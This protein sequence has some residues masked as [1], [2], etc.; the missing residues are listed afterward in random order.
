MAFQFHPGI[1][2]K[3]IRTRCYFITGNEVQESVSQTEIQWTI[4]KMNR[5]RTT[6]ILLIAKYITIIMS[7]AVIALGLS[8]LIG[9][10]WRIPFLIQYH[11]D[12]IAMV[13][14]TA[15]SFIL[16]G[17]GIYSL[18]YRQP[19]VARIISAVV[20]F[21]ATIILLQYFLGINSGID[22]LF[23]NHYNKTAN[24]F[25]GRM[26]PNTA[27]CFM[28][29]A[30]ALFFLGYRR[31]H[32]YT[33]VVGGII[34]VLTLSLSILF[35]S[36]YMSSLHQGYLWGSET[37]MAANT[38]IG[39]LLLGISIITLTAYQAK[40]ND[41]G[42]SKSL[43]FLIAFCIFITVILLA[44]EIKEGQE[45]YGRVS[46]LPET[47]IILGLL[48]ALLFGLVLRF[49]LTASSAAVAARKSWSL[50]RSTMD[51][52]EDGIMVTDTQGKLADFNKKFLE[53]WRLEGQEIRE[54]S[55][56]NITH[57]I[58]N[59]L[60]DKEKYLL[61]IDTIFKHPEEI[62]THELR[63][64][65]GCV[66]ELSSRP[67]WLDDK[68][69]GRVWCF[70]DTTLQKRLQDELARQATHD[71]LTELPNRALLLDLINYSIQQASRAHNK[72]VAL[73]LLDLDRFSKINDLF[74]RSKGDELLKL[75]GKRLADF[76]PDGNT[77]GRIGGDEFL[78]I[79]G[80]LHRIEDAAAMS[81]QLIMA[82][83]EPFRFYDNEINV[84]CS[85]GIS[86]YPK[87]GKDVDTLLSN[88]DI[89]LSR[90]K[91][92]GRDGFQFYTTE[93]NRYTQEYLQIEQELRGALEKE[94]LLLYYQP[95]FDFTKDSP[96][97]AEAL[98]RWNNPK[99][100]LIYPVDF[101]P[102]AEEIGLIRKIGTW[103]I[104]EAC[105]QIRQW[106]DNGLIDFKL[107]INI[108]AMQFKFGTLGHDLK[109]SLQKNKLLPGA[110]EIELTESILIEHSDDVVHALDEIK[111]MGVTITIDDFGTGYSS[112]SYI[113]RF[114]ID[115]L[116]IDK[117]FIADLPANREDGILVKTIIGMAKSLGIQVLAEGVETRE[118][119]TLLKN[120]GCDLVQGYYFAKPLPASEFITFFNRPQAS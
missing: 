56:A 15:L 70:H 60:S 105:R 22:E 63:L 102:L 79:A 69:I 55:Y 111:K 109:R 13:Y 24:T 31:F 14:N 84:T 52:T 117:S 104:K 37:P 110:L 80:N 100:G 25:P 38:A 120:M 116:K 42:I 5:V 62:F 17:T 66:F 85:I 36:G 74:G 97:G 57:V 98:I 21:G 27:V 20:F 86:L 32:K 65:N 3:L 99:R 35:I 48:F 90:V 9:W 118:Q 119:M 75:V 95:V 46:T 44:L 89:A 23:F 26:A 68:I 41:L 49:A 6:T 29:T 53:M 64:A 112:L 59:Q 12:M 39:F 91:K 16:V 2:L 47:V 73:I 51:S 107:A 19:L 83:Q 94:E 34:G 50:L 76:L 113:K 96:V 115:K 78:M 61:K 87:D 81:N 93:M 72:V 58:A 7:L 18:I 88:A 30:T 101:I 4:D 106:Q 92:E 11:P 54:M 1:V 40:Q 71:S 33:V 114:H 45:Q 8:V 108:S 28:L 103:V 67:Q 82:L 10:Y 77:L 43:P